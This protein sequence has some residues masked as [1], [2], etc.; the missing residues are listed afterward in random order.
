MCVVSM[1]YLLRSCPSH[2]CDGEL[3][4][5]NGGNYTKVKSFLRG[6]YRLG[7]KS[8]P[9]VPDMNNPSISQESYQYK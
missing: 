7:I 3:P 8:I 9:T 1:F 2:R 6:R 5:R 4:A